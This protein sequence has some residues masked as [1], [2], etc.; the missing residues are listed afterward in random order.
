MTDPQSSPLD[1]APEAAQARYYQRTAARY[2]VEHGDDIENQR[3][4]AHIA[5]FLADLDVRSVLDIGT[6][7]GR[8]LSFLADRLPDV[9][10]YGVD[11]VAELV[12]QAQRHHPTGLVQGSAFELPFPDASVDAV[13]ETAVLHHLAEPATAVAEMLRVARRA[14]FIADANRF[15]QGRPLMRAAKLAL[16]RTGLWR[17]LVLARTRGRGWF[18]SEGDGLFYSYSAYDQ[19]AQVAEW[20]DDTLVLPTAGTESSSWLQPLLTAPHVLVVA[21]RRPPVELDD[22]H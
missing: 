11:P 18:W 16:C 1:A 8:G 5:R 9:D 15:G 2:D 22:R 4:L 6:G 3:A 19:L 10:L 7:T 20:A 12:H 17:P 21:I 13:I 14:V